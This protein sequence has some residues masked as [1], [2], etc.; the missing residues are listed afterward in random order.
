MNLSLIPS[1]TILSAQGSTRP[2]SAKFGMR[3]DCG[4]KWSQSID[5][6]RNLRFEGY[7]HTDLSFL[8]AK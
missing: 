3:T 4:N 7:P 8:T 1:A 2:V 5:N 6:E